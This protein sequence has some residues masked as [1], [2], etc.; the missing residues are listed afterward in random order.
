M[1]TDWLEIDDGL[2]TPVNFSGSVIISDGFRQDNISQVINKTLKELMDIEIRDMGEPLRI[3][4][5]YAAIDNI[6]GV[7]SVELDSPT[8]TITPAIN[9]ILVLGSIN[10]TISLRGVPAYGTNF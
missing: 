3:S 7:L 9:E 5:V 8:Q 10:F 6:E 2:Y 1:L 4:D